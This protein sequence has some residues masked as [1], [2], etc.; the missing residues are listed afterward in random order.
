[1]NHSQPLILTELLVLQAQSGSRRAMN[2]LVEVWTPTLARRAYRLTQDHEGTHEVLQ[3]SWVGIA[4]GIGR[5]R[6]P[7]RFGPWSLRI[8]HNKAA[9]WIGTRA[10]DRKITPARVADMPD[11]SDEQEGE[12]RNAESTELIR[13]AVSKLDS[14][15]RE[16]VYLFYMDQCTIEQI[17]FVLKIPAG[18][19][20]TRLTKAR[21]ELK[22]FMD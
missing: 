19:V 5:L 2:Q 21:N 10:A 4:R 13:I 12:S 20:K 17:A 22:K 14:K 7:S 11:V 15:L 3:E 8:V 6:E 16:V 9:D 1:M 18:T